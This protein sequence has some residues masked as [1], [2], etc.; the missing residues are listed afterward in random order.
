MRL[1]KLL[2]SL[3]WYEVKASLIWSYPDTNES[4]DGYKQVFAELCELVPVEPKMRIIIQETFREAL[5]EE[6]FTEVIGRNGTLNRDQ[7]DY[8]HLEASVGPVYSNSETDFSLSLESWEQWLGME[9]DSGSLENYTKLEI[10]AHCIWDMTFHGFEQLQI[11]EEK[12]ELKRRVDELNSMTEQEK[13]EKL[14]PMEQMMKK[15]EEWKEEN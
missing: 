5:D 9:I 15:L 7:E 13:N 6:P 12:E 14:I 8:K 2:R 11:R 10:A 4:I 3:G 1:S